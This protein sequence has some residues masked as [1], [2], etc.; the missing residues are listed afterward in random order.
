MTETAIQVHG[1]YG[2]F[3]DYPV[4][5]FMRDITPLAWWELGAGVHTLLYVAQT[6][7]QHDGQDF[8]NLLHEM[9]R[10]VAKH[11]DLSHVQDLVLDVE[12]RVNLLGEMGLYFS[13]CAKEGKVLIPL[14]NGTPLIHFVGDICVGWLLFWQACI[15][16][17]RLAAI[18]AKNHIDPHDASERSEFL[19]KNQEAAFYDGKLN[20][21]RFFIKNVL[22]HVDS[23]AAAI[24]NEDLSLMAIH[25]SGF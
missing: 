12:K 3:S 25:D 7:A 8:V 14:S 11:R 22:P 2:F 10:T 4:Q 20:S 6:M 16:G 5:Q 17:K 9:H 23:V 21:A 1:R 18:L 15:A 13:E 24:K 19:S